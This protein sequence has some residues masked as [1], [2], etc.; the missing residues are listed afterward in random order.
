MELCGL[1]PLTLMEVVT[2]FLGIGDAELLFATGAAFHRG[3]KSV[4]VFPGTSSGAFVAEGAFDMGFAWEHFSSYC[5]I[6]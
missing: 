4:F 5:T 1:V 2:A 3:V 6:V